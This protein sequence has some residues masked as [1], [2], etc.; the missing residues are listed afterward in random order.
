ME[1]QTF[2]ILID[3]SP[4]RVWEI[5]LGEKTYP[6]WTSIFCEGSMVETDWQEGSKTLF[7]DGNRNGMVSVIARNIQN[8]FLSIKHLGEVKNGVEDTESESVK[9]WAGCFENYTLKSAD[10]LTELIIDIDITEEFKDYFINTWPKALDK[11][12]DLAEKKNQPVG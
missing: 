11:V 1:K 6:E 2:K 7:L 12:K 3:A 9:K 10:G 5:L 8:E 4:S